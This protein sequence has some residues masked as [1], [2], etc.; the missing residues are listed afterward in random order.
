VPKRVRAGRNGIVISSAVLSMPAKIVSPAPVGAVPVVATTSITPLKVPSGPVETSL[1]PC[2]AE[3]VVETIGS[4]PPPP[5][6][7]AVCGQR[8]S[9]FADFDFTTSAR[10]NASASANSLS[11]LLAKNRSLSQPSDVSSSA[12]S[13]AGSLKR[14]RIEGDPIKGAKKFCEVHHRA[15]ECI[16]R[17]SEK[18]STPLKK[19]EQHEAYIA[20]HRDFVFVFICA[21]WLT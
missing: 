8:T 19:T 7:A 14:C 16:R 17:A 9:L 4:T 18:G 11:E 20:P 1:V 13:A 15:V 10:T 12:G 6:V 5:I 3:K 2:G 21:A